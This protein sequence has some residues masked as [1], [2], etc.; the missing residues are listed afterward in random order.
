[1]YNPYPGVMENAPASN[2]YQGGFMVDLMAKDLG[3]AFD[4]AVKSRCSIPMGSMARNLF[5]LHAA[6]GNGSLDFSSIQKMF[7]DLD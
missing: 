5:A 4:S 3:L 7:A 2:G 6:N 1:V